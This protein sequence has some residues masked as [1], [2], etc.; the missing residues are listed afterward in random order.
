[1]Y[2]RKAPARAVRASAQRRV[3]GTANTFSRWGLTNHVLSWY[4]LALLPLSMWEEHMQ[5]IEEAEGWA[6][7]PQSAGCEGMVPSVGQSRC[8]G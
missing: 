1:M 7:A 6:C 8:E 4:L 2:S 3:S 5:L